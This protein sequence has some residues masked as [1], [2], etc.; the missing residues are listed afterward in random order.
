MR[1]WTLRWLIPSC[2]LNVEVGTLLSAASREK[3][4]RS[5]SSKPCHVAGTRVAG[6]TLSASL[7]L[8]AV[9]RQRRELSKTR[10]A[11]FVC[12]LL[13]PL[14][15]G[16]TETTYSAIDSSLGAKIAHHRVSSPL[17]CWTVT[18]CGCVYSH[19]TISCQRS[20]SH[21][22]STYATVIAPDW[23][24]PGITVV[25]AAPE[26]DRRAHRRA[27]V[28]ASTPKTELRAPQL[29]RGLICIASTRAR[30]VS[31][32]IGGSFVSFFGIWTF[33]QTHPCNFVDSDDTMN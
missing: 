25:H 3:S 12:T 17:R 28:L 14:T 27:T 4:F 33:L 18:T 31:D 6:R 19:S 32:S 22:I 29:I 20:T 23:R 26:D 15:W 8:S 16:R 21:S 24:G 10:I 11:I 7:L 5:V 2:S 9:T 30:S 13:T 1:R